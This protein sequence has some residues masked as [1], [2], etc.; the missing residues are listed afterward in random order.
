M[1]GEV[2]LGILQITFAG[3]DAKIRALA[4]K[5]QW[6]K[7]GDLARE[8]L[9]QAFE[10]VVQVLVFCSIGRFDLAIRERRMK[11]FPPRHP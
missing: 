2:D 9:P 7:A 1:M 6:P 8:P 3:K 4:L 5:Q 11:L 10:M